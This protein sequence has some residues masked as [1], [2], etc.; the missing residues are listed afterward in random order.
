MHTGQQ[1]TIPGDTSVQ[2]RIAVGQQK[3][4]KLEIY[5]T[6]Q[7]NIAKTCYFT[8]FITEYILYQLE[9]YFGQHVIRSK[10][11]KEPES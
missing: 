1:N 3:R 7:E 5:K 11:N 10:K 2:N 8:A 9:N 6:G 4:L